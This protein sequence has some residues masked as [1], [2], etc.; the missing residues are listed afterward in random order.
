MSQETENDN[1]VAEPKE[2]A[3][4]NEKKESEITK[5]DSSKKTL[6]FSFSYVLFAVIAYFAV[7][8]VMNGQEAAMDKL[9]WLIGALVVAA[10]IKAI[11]M[12]K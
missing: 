5:E 9:P 8:W 12:R 3:E 10:I 2:D 6:S 7:V 11:T 4:A 1:L